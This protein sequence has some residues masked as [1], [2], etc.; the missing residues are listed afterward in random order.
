MSLWKKI[1][2]SMLPKS[3]S[4][5]F[6]PKCGSYNVHYAFGKPKRPNLIGISFGNKLRCFDCGYT[7]LFPVKKVKKNSKK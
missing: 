3:F 1:S 4:V 7:G 5:K 6:C 2:K